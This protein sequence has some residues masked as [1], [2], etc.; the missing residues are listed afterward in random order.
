MRKIIALL[1]ST[2]LLGVA[3]GQ[4]VIDGVLQGSPSSF[5]YLTP[6]TGSS[7]DSWSDS[8]VKPR[9]YSNGNFSGGADGAITIGNFS[10]RFI[11]TEDST[12]SP[13][14]DNCFRRII[15]NTT[16]NMPVL[17]SAWN[18][19][20]YPETY[21]D[22]V[23]QMGGPT[24]T[25]NRG[26]HAQ[27][28]L[29]SFIPDTNN[30]V[31]LLQFAFVAENAM[32]ES[33]APRNP[34]VEFVLL[35]H[36]TNDILSIGSYD[37]SHP[38]AQFWF[39][40]PQ[41]PAYGNIPDP[42]NTPLPAFVSPQIIPK[43]SCNCSTNDIFTFPYTIVAFDLSAQA[44]SHQAVDFRI[45]EW[46]CS[47]EVH[48]AYCYYA[49]KMIPAQLNVD[50]CGGDSLNLSIPWGYDEQSYSWYNGVDS[51]STD[52]SNWFDPDD[53]SDSIVVP[54]STKFNPILHPDPAKPYYRCT[55]QSITG[56]PF[57]YQ[58]TVKYYDLKPSFMV[59]SVIP[60]EGDSS[61]LGI[62]V[63]N[64]SQIGIVLP[65]GNGGVDTTWQ[66][67]ELNP[68][69]CVWNFGDGTPDVYGFEPSHVYADTGTYTVSLYVT[70][71]QRECVSASVDTIIVLLP[72][73]S[74]VIDLLSEASVCIYPNPTSG[75]V[76]L[77]LSGLN[78]RTI[79]LFSANGQLLNTVVPTDETITL[80]LSNYAAGIYFV[81]IHSDKA[82][83]TQK[84]IKR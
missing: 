27:E 21:I 6:Q 33:H 24:G 80:S 13:A 65:D 17:P 15:G 82:V 3:M 44:R 43:G 81:R 50:Y 66:N 54:G 18:S 79:E 59:E 40:T 47:A 49:A 76:T 29:Y 20:K 67:M 25:T 31:L 58:A 42:R 51:A 26:L 46:A 30:P 28:M 69:Q 19:D 56:I 68:E 83:T 64:T 11:T 55:V 70:D 9:T 78:A 60:T 7:S 48:W 74:S 16:Y 37:S 8:W 12:V 61:S 52:A 73:P 77:D 1:L 4:Q 32:H 34:G 72:L 10:H 63:H 14:N 41:G 36:G 53:P 35:N 84:I 5:M 39:G 71:Y 22:S 57:T 45:R 2:L 38:Y 62:V 75:D 23:I